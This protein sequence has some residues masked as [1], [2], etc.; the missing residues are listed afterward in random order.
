MLKG[1]KKVA[2]SSRSTHFSRRT[3]HV[4]T[5]PYPAIVFSSNSISSKAT[6]AARYSMFKTN[7]ETL[8]DVGSRADFIYCLS[9]CIVSE[10]HV[11]LA[12][13]A[14]YLIYPIL[15]HALQRLET[16]ET[17]N[18]TSISPTRAHHARLPS[19][20]NGPIYQ[21]TNFWMTPWSA[22]NSSGDWSNPHYQRSLVVSQ[23]NIYISVQYLLSSQNSR[24][25]LTNVL[26]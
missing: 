8:Q 4:M 18:K 3:R 5:P 16:D 1:R 21:M 13:K 7:Q 19:P 10:S 6:P 24:S 20:V 22:Q 9:T 11:F 23:T 17:C 12:R 14:I 25:K 2:V 15:Y 26:A